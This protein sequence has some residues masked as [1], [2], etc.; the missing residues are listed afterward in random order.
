MAWKDLR[1]MSQ[2]MEFVERG[3]QPGSNVAALCRE[4]GIARQTGHKWL[5]R[6]RAF[7][8]DGLEEQSR[9][10]KTTPSATAE[11]IVLAIL[12]LKESHPG[13]G[14]K[15]LEPLLRKKLCG[16]GTPSET[17]IARILERF[18]KVR[19]RRRRQVMSIVDRAPTIV[20]QAPNHVWTVDFKGWWRTG[21]ELRCEPL[22][23][24]DAYSRFILCSTVLPGPGLAET[25]RQFE[26][27]FRVFGIPETIQCDNGNP[28]VCTKSRGGLTRLSAWW[29]SMGIIIVRSRLGCPQDNG[30]HER[31]HRDIAEQV[32]AHYAHSRPAQQRALQRWRQEFN[33]V[34]PHEALDQKVPAEFYQPKNKRLP[35]VRRAA[36]PVGWLV[37][38]VYGK[39]VICLKN[40]VYFVSKA[41]NGYNV[42]LQPLKDLKYRVWFYEHDLGELEIA[43]TEL[44]IEGIVRRSSKSAA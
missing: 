38:Q 32:E 11:D 44:E 22:T 42:G 1:A 21:D 24:R 2:K 36:Y 34:R 29:V 6:F 9:R 27:L 28:F 23:V 20:A 13:W 12:E 39:G 35:V 30:A 43:P 31:M 25:K 26:K 4:Y 19:K 8:Y 14:P 3:S 18:G 7:G 15:K 17:T 40:S 33:H 41:L 5:K 16:A 10:P 37:R